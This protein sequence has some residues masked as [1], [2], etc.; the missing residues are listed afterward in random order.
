MKV[1]VALS[2][3]P[4]IADKTALIRVDNIAYQ[5]LLQAPEAGDVTSLIYFLTE[6][7]LKRAEYKALCEKG[8]R[9][10][11]TF[12]TIND[13]REL[14]SA[15]RRNGLGVPPL[16]IT[17]MADVDTSSKHRYVEQMIFNPE[18]IRPRFIA[19]PPR[20]TT[21][22]DDLSDTEENARGRSPSY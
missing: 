20:A 13:L 2:S 18:P 9:Y 11:C 12:D 16:Y 8:S 19:P 4:L 17:S 7:H 10:F 21:E 15:F 14:Y 22:N 6:E 1:Y 3:S 5:W